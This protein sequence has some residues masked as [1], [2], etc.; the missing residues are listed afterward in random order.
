MSEDV[1]SE[2]MDK[3]EN[4][5]NHIDPEQKKLMRS[6]GGNV[7]NA[8]KASLISLLMNQFSKITTYEKAISG[9]LTT[10][11][12]RTK[13][14][15]TQ[16]LITFLG[17]L[18]KASSVEVKTVMDMFKKSD[19]DVKQFMKEVQ[20]LIKERPTVD[21]DEVKTIVKPKVKLSMDKKEKALRV[22]KMLIDKEAEDIE[23]EV[24]EK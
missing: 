19:N 20:K 13:M 24:E 23:S 9:A 22:M 7:E 21:E 4:P 6:L 12:Q 11:T 10:L 8:V 17:V 5:E 18:T 14:M 2:I 1:F 15:D 3:L 16:E